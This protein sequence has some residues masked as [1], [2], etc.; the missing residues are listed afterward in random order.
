MG[1]YEAEFLGEAVPVKKVRARKTKDEPKVTAVEPV[2]PIEKVKRKRVKKVPETM[3]E[4]KPVEIPTP[5]PTE[6]EESPKQEKVETISPPQPPPVEKKVL[7]RKAVEEKKHDE[8]P[9]AWFKTWHLNEAKRQNLAKKKDERV[10][11]TTVKKAA[12][13]VA[14]KQWDDGYTRD[15]IRHEQ[16]NHQQ[17]MYQMIHGKRF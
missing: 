14:S 16:D 13:S 15:K 12:H 4:L 9:P 2:A 17:R 7:K 3:P 6:V 5:E 1:L 11:I 10:A 8:E